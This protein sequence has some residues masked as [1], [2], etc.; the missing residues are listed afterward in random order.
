[1][2]FL[3]LVCEKLL[4]WA[5]AP[6]AALG[7]PMAISFGGVLWGW[8]S[9]FTAPQIFLLAWA[10]LGLSF[11]A[12][13]GLICLIFSLRR[14]SL[15]R[16]LQA[17]NKLSRLRLRIIDEFWVQRAN[18][19]GQSV[20]NDYLPVKAEIIKVFADF[21]GQSIADDFYAI[22]DFRKFYQEFINGDEAFNKVYSIINRDMNYLQTFIVDFNKKHLQA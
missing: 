20:Y 3:K 7:G 9:Q 2:W 11:F 5:I 13:A 19:N 14:F 10:G 22:G 8:W 15:Y 12:W 21:F 1:M 16:E 4:D 6:Q 17:I 18:A